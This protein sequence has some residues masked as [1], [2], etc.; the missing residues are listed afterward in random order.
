MSY[1]VS[2][3]Y[4]SASYTW[5]VS[6]TIQLATPGQCHILCSYIAT[7]GQCHILFSQL[8]LVSVTYYAASYTWLV[9]HTMQLAT[10]GQC[11]ILSLTR[12]SQ[13]HLKHSY[14]ELSDLIGHSETTS[15]QGMIIVPFSGLFG[16]GQCI[17]QTPSGPQQRL[18]SLRRYILGL[19]YPRA[20]G[21]SQCLTMI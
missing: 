14:H 21:L 3:T 16:N 11:H 1:I 9:S 7:P 18:S 20:F 19:L 8:H 4:Y 12:C 15:S 5:L 13:L 6:H 2:V 10:P 17:I